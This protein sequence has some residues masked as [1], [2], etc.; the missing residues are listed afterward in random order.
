MNKTFVRILVSASL[1]VGTTGV[2]LQAAPNPYANTFCNPVNVS[3]NFWPQT[4]STPPSYREAADPGIIVYKNNY[5]LFASHS[6]GYWWSTD[7]LNWNFVTP[8]GLNV[9]N[10]APTVEIKGDTMYYTAGGASIY[11][12]TDPK[13][14]VWTVAGNAAPGDPCLFRDSDGK[15]YC[16]GG[17]SA[18]GVIT[19]EQHDPTKSFSVIGKIDTCITSDRNDHGF[20]VPGDCNENPTNDSWIEGS[21]MTKYNTLYFLQYAVP[22]TQYRSYSDGC[23]VGPSPVGPFTFC[24]NS[25]MCMKP[26]GFVTGT[27]HSCTF[28]DV[29]GKY[30]HITTMVVSVL[31]GFER[32]LAIF[33]AGFDSANLLH[34]DTYLGDYPQYL[35]GKAPAN[36]ANN[37]FGGMLLSFKKTAIASS[38]LS[39]FPASNAFDENIKTW[40]SATS[41]N[42]G[43]WLRVDLGKSCAVGAIQTNFAEQDI[44][45]AGGRGTS[46]SHKYKIEGTN[47]TTATWQMLVNKTANTADV[48]HDYTPLDSIVN[49]RYI[50]VTNAGPM[51]AG[52]KFAIRDLRVFGNAQ[53]SAPGAIASFTITRSSTDKRMATVTWTKVADADGY[54]IRLGTAANKLYNNYQVL[55]K[56]SASCVIRS[57]NVGVT[58][59][60]TMDTYSQCGVTQGTVVKRD[61][62]NNVTASMPMSPSSLVL[63]AGRT[64]YEVIGNR[65]AVPREFKGKLY[66]ARVYDISG[67]LLYSGTVQNGIIDIPKNI[68]KIT[69]VSIVKFSPNR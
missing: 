65:F 58:Y 32:R 45:Y 21:W 44:T 16:Y 60:F 48:P 66:V 30:W 52:G 49:V 33:P 56:D 28:R 41:A 12:T 18:N 46:F 36:T 69:G 43:E 3:Y 27:G 20:E 13:A 26:Q 54:I 61:D 4:G 57:L 2:S 62:N 8:T 31:A 11:M 39:G 17:C 51:P 50:K 15:F 1:V 6:G 40:W 53:C 34:T 25:P 42:A 63:Q 38:T 64:T 5:Y 55:S 7:M 19:V 35:P 9:D 14:G 10:Y 47:D 67:K 23:Y 37:L 22:G 59:Y 29:S 68:D 24:A